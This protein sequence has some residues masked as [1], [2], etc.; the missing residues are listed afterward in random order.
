MNRFYED[1]KLQEDKIEPHDEYLEAPLDKM[2]LESGR[3]FW[4][5]FTEIFVKVTV[6]TV[7]ED[8]ARSGKRL[9]SK[10]VTPFLRNY[11]PWM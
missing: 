7:E 6:T 4:T 11:A 1:F 10:C 8:L 9:Q 3:Y 5:I 2:K